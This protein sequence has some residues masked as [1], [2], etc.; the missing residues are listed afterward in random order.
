MLDPTGIMAVINGAMALYSAIQ[1]FIK[2]LREMLEVVNS[3]VNGV[4]DVAKGN[5]TT[6]ANYLENTL[7][8]A[9]PIV[10]G[11]LA[12]QVGLSGIGARIG[13]LIESAK[14][15]IDEALTWLVNKAVDT[16]MNM[17]DRIMG[18][19]GFGEEETADSRSVKNDA[20]TRLLSILGPE[21]SVEK[22]RTASNTVLKELRPRGLRI[23]RVVPM[24]GEENQFKIEAAASPIE[25]LFELIPAQFQDKSV[26]LAV[27]IT[28]NDQVNDEELGTTGDN[29]GFA[30]FG[31]FGG[32]ENRGGGVFRSRAGADPNHVELV[33]WNTGSVNRHRDGN[34][35]HAEHQFEGWINQRG[36][37]FKRKITHIN[38]HLSG[39]S[40]CDEC[41]RTLKILS[42]E[43]RK[44]NPTA[45]F[46]VGWSEVY[47]SGGSPHQ[48]T[49][50]TGIASLITGGWDF[51]GSSLPEGLTPE[52]INNARAQLKVRQPA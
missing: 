16:G 50:T 17:L 36:E 31:N 34:R 9:L 49:S 8:R 51:S 2:Y 42:S 43:I 23:L 33:T 29:R 3:F 35:T 1:S 47:A 44:Y 14:A 11:F 26:N 52:N 7:G 18:R 20:K 15:L 19:G 39:V 41:C 4:A 21:S 40:P 38:L 24:T 10:I 6:A 37:T 12:N 22:A 45:T 48:R 46:H 32:Q 27:Q 13:T 28:I 5:V 30:S 25:E